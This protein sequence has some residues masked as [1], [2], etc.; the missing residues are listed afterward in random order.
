VPSY[1]DRTTR[2]LHVGLV[3]VDALGFL[4]GRVFVSE[5]LSNFLLGG[6]Q[7]RLVLLSAAKSSSL[8]RVTFQCVSRLE[9]LFL[10]LPVVTAFMLIVPALFW[11]APDP[12]GLCRTYPFVSYDML[13]VWARRKNTA[14]AGQ[15][16]IQIATD[17]SMSVQ[18]AS[19]VGLGAV[20][21][22]DF[23]PT[24]ITR[25]VAKVMQTKPDAKSAMIAI[26]CARNI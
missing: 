7:S 12:L 22:P 1:Q 15:Q 17:D 5:G 9:I 4:G 25:R 19:Q 13:G 10:L 16:P 11:S 21:S 23:L 26:F 8:L 18:N 24:C 2:K 6:N 3:L 14:N 20:L